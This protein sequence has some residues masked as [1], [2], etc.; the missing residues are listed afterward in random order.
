[1]GV[2]EGGGALPWGGGVC[3]GG[4]GRPRRRPVPRFD[5]RQLG[6]SGDSSGGRPAAVGNPRPETSPQGTGGDQVWLVCTTADCPP[7]ERVL[8][9]SPVLILNGFAFARVCTGYQITRV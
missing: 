9:S 5:R 6:T 4:E 3:E 2:V 7:E 1:M 8:P